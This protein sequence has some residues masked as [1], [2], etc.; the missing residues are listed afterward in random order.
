MRWTP[1]TRREYVAI[2]TKKDQ[3]ES[4]EDEAVM[5]L[6]DESDSSSSLSLPQRKKKKNKEK[7]R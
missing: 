5:G 2:D 7:N 3:E 1:F 4:S 6:N